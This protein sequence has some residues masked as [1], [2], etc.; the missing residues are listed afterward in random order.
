M[1]AEG[2]QRYGSELEV[3]MSQYRV[4]IRPLEAVATVGPLL[5]FTIATVEGLLRAGYDPIAQPIS[6]LALGP[7]G[8]IQ[9]A[10]FA[11]LA[12]SLLSFTATLSLRLRKGVAALAGPL[13]FSVM[14]VG[15]V[16]AGT[17]TMDAAGAPP[18]LAG[19]LHTLG[20]FLFFPW[21]P[22]VLLLIARRFRRD[23]RFRP[24]FRYTMATGLWCLTTMIFFFV[25]VGVPGF[26]R[27][28]AFAG[29]VQRAQLLPFL[30]WISL[31]AAYAG[32]HAQAAF[33][34][35]RARA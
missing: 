34:S 13:I 31:T 19:K 17:F 22:V 3:N 21:M 30:V 9:Q 28:S 18:T 2:S 12:L 33:E 26:S 35:A 29:L 5:F 4:I 15:I 1:R 25:F 16:L 23:E 24:Y 8:W 32:R 7:R 11:L 10:N 6:A 27:L 20:G 14:T